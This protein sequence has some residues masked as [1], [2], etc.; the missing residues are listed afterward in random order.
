M[1]DLTIHLIIHHS[2][3]DFNFIVK[4]PCSAYQV[5]TGVISSRSNKGKDIIVHNSGVFT[6]YCSFS[7]LFFMII[8]FTLLSKQGAKKSIWPLFA[9]LLPNMCFAA[10]MLYKASVT[11]GSGAGNSMITG[12]SSTINQHYCMLSISST[13]TGYQYIISKYYPNGT[14]IAQDYQGT[15][16]TGSTIPSAI[17]SILDVRGGC[18]NTRVNYVNG[19]KTGLFDAC[20]GVTNCPEYSWTTNAFDTATQLIVTPNLVFVLIGYDT[21]ATKSWLGYISDQ[22][23]FQW[24]I[25]LSSI[26]FQGITQL[27][28]STLRVI[29][30]SGTQCVF[31]PYYI[32]SNKGTTITLSISDTSNC[33]DIFIATNTTIFTIGSNLK[34]STSKGLAVKLDNNGVILGIYMFGG[35]ATDSF[36]SGLTHPDGTIYL[37]GKTSLISNGGTDAWLMAIDV[38]GNMLWQAN[39]GTASDENFMAMALVGDSKLMC[40]G[41]SASSMY[42]VTVILECAKATIANPSRTDCVSVCSPGY[43]YAYNVSTCLPCAPGTF[44]SSP[45]FACEDC[46][47]GYYQDN[48]GQTSCKPCSEN[49]YSDMPGQSTCTPCAPGYYQCQFGQPIC[50]LCLKPFCG[51][52]QFN[53]R[54]IC[55]QLVGICWQAYDNVC[56][57]GPTLTANCI[58][59]VAKI[60]YAIW[61]V[62]GTTDSQCA[63][64]KDSFNMELMKKKPMLQSAVYAVDGQSFT[65]TFDCEINQKKIY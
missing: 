23:G 57:T 31:I 25:S 45:G 29:G 51:P 21:T 4:L 50:S 61:Y 35:G 28:D 8:S 60:C 48:A 38:N 37:A 34:G 42:S 58:A 43:F 30:L 20:T 19:V 12:V 63:D 13:A 24:L 18:V 22:T 52:C 49:Y 9:F 15:I 44:S 53:D 46:P 40:V 36:N 41:S 5:A 32:L 2:N 65:L 11:A 62:N 56:I 3:A 1:P 27:A 17:H 55:D 16:P 10:P 59:A 6:P 47:R 54:T 64:F 7:I 39:Y 33:L 14:L 26:R